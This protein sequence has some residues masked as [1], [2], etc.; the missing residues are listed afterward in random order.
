MGWGY[1]NEYE[2]LGVGQGF[3]GHY[4]NFRNENCGTFFVECL[5]CVFAIIEVSVGGGALTIWV[6]FSAMFMAIGLFNGLVN[7]FVFVSLWQVG[8]GG[9]F[10]YRVGN[11]TFI[12]YGD[13]Q[14][15]DIVVVQ[16][17]GVIFFRR[18]VRFEVDGG[19]NGTIGYFVSFLWF[20][21][22][23]WV[24]IGRLYVFFV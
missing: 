9:L 3:F 8:S 4:A 22:I 18:F 21:S 20:L 15:F 14:V 2:I 5:W 17:I 23:I 24:V 13:W 19:A 16:P 7:G 6:R 11:Y 1:V 10:F 12:G